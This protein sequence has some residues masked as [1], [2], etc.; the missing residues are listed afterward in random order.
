V[1]QPALIRTGGFDAP[2]A[3]DLDT[4]V[5][6]LLFIAIFLAI[7]VSFHPYPDLSQPL[8][9]VSE[10]GDLVNQIGF[11]ALFLTFA[12]WALFHEPR[13]LLVL[14]RP[15]FV[16]VLAWCMLTAATSWEPALSAR[17]LIFTLVMLSLAGIVLLLPKN[18]RH[19][20]ELLAATVLIVLALCYLG[21]LFAPQLSIHQL[22]DFHETEHAGEWRGV[23]P[24]KNYAG[25]TMALFIL[26]GMF[27]ARVRSVAVG[28]TIIV[29][30][31]VFLAF[32]MAKT[33][34]GMLP[35]T[36]IVSAFVARLRRPAIGVTVVIA[37]LVT[38]SLLTVGSVYFESVRDLLDRF[39]DDPSFTGRTDLWQFALKYLM[40]HPI[41]GFGFS[42]FWGTPQVV[43]DL[44]DNA[45]WVNN[46]G[47]AHNAY[48]NLA[49]WMGIPG[50]L[51]VIVWVVVMPVADFYRRAAE[52][53]G[54]ALQLL[55][56]RIL[57]FSVYTSCFENSIFQQIDTVW[58]PFVVAAFGLRYLSAA[59]TSP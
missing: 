14:L 53:E 18:I 10:G 33:A 44:G 2:A 46:A 5:R 34:I 49:L 24:H 58:F 54:R 25:I 6:S 28:G 23:F 31:M 26:I 20:S 38:F 36:L 51:L 9:P 12:A 59:R 7:W 50:L 30:S 35:F 13:R 19:F 29:L 56:L 22:T 4:L 45:T 48:L 1:A 17:R 57:L 15:T 42:A 55:F 52:P 3:T 39:L 16:A 41:L 40:Q 47:D 8:P 27:V 32:S 43:Y 11:S 37:G 21:V